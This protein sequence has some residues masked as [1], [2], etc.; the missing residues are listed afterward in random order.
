MEEKAQRIV[1]AAIALAEAGGFQA[2]RLRDVAT[3]ADVAL[4]TLYSRF[5]SKEDILVAAL[6]QQAMRFVE[7][8]GE[9][10]IHGETPTERLCWLFNVTSLGLFDR[11]NFSRAVIRSV[12]SGLPGISEK[13]IR[14]QDP[15]SRL[16]LG[17]LYGEIPAKDAKLLKADRTF[18]HVLLHTW[19]GELVGWVSGSRTEDEV[20]A[21]MADAVTLLMRAREAG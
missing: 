19:F 10:N 4:G 7:I 12:A 8:V 14:Y 11:P 13:V 16:V 15:M 20:I 18:V 17:A 1:D 21:S 3:H 2:V 6:E 5:S 9:V